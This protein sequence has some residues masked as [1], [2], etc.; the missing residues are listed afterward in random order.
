M[1]VLGMARIPYARWLKWI[2]PILLILVV[3]GLLL[4]IPTLTMKLNG[5]RKYNVLTTLRRRPRSRCNL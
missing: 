2:M 3:L 5:F 4:L 1:G